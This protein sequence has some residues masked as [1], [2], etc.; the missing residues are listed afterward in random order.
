[1]AIAGQIAD[2]ITDHDNPE[3]RDNLREALTIALN[4][5]PEAVGMLIGTP[6]IEEGWFENWDRM[7]RADGWCPK[8][9]QSF[10]VHNGD[11][12]CVED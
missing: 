4:K 7:E 10:A 1:M 12:S 3:D 8:C 6:L 2:M 11:G 9:G 5:S